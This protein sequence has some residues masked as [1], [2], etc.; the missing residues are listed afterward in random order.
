MSDGG[1]SLAFLPAA[2]TEIIGLGYV[3]QSAG[4]KEQKKGKDLRVRAR[5]SAQES[6]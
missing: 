4:L 6:L 5:A 2:H 3:L 1:I